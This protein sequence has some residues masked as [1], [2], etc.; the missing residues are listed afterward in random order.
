MKDVFFDFES[1]LFH[2]RFH[3]VCSAQD[4]LQVVGRIPDGET[5]LGPSSCLRLP[6][7]GAGGAAG[8]AE[9][10]PLQEAVG[11]GQDPAGADQDSSAEEPL[12]WRP[13]VLDKEG[14]L[15]RVGG[16]VRVEPS[17]NAELRPIVLSQAAG[18]WVGRGQRREMRLEVL[19]QR[20]EHPS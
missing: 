7:R 2:F 19:R 1:L 11:G 16:D 5:A 15:P 8:P 13:L 4:H 20:P 12:S 3:P 18:G 9:S 6:L 17:F 10:L 14:S